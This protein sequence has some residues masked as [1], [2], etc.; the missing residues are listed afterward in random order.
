MSKVQ[1]KDM[2]VKFG[3]LITNS[4]S[5]LK[6]ILKSLGEKANS[7]KQHYIMALVSLIQRTASTLLPA[8]L[9]S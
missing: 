3:P 6:G 7:E 9:K 4:V 8:E 1:E 5:I 2:V